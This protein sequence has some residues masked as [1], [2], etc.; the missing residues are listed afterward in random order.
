MQEELEKAYMGT[1]QAQERQNTNILITSY[2]QKLSMA[3]N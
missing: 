2:Q 3:N 1:S